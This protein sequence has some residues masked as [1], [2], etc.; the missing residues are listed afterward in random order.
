MVTEYFLFC[1]GN[2]SSSKFALGTFFDMYSQLQWSK[3]YFVDV[4]GRS[5]EEMMR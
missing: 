1:V 5:I 2:T 3:I 4:I